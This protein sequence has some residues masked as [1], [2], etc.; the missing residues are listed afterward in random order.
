VDPTSIRYHLS[1]GDFQN[2]LT[3]ELE[4]PALAEAL[5]KVDANQSDLEA[6]RKEVLKLV[7]S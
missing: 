5:N 4:E 3:N 1:R 6:L 7:K 2:W